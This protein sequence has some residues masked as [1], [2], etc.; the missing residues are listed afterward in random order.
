M[1]SMRVS[2]EGGTYKPGMQFGVDI[3]GQIVRVEPVLHDWFIRRK[4]A[5]WDREEKKKARIV[6]DDDELD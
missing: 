6:A 3:D 4:E 2:A 1:T 5:L